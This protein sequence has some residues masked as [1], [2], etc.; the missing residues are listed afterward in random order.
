MHRATLIALSPV[1]ALQGLW[2]RLR[3]ARLSEAT[4]PR[5]GVKGT[6]PEVRVLITGDSSAAGVGVA[7]QEQA[8]AGRLVHHLAPRYCVH[9]TLAARCG[10]TAGST[11]P[12]LYALPDAQFDVAVIALGVNDAKNGGSRQ[13]WRTDY[14]ALISLLRTRFGVKRILISGVPQLGEFPLL[15]APLRTVLGRRAA[16]FDKDLQQMIAADPDL[17]YVSLHFPMDPALMASDGFHPGAQVYDSW[18]QRVAE[19][20]P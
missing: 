2:V 1:L 7:T 18:A 4:G 14:A 10:A 5:N 20:I 6:G 16:L 15:P 8:L 13:R 3:A 11:L 19:Q 17:H 12:R 9:W